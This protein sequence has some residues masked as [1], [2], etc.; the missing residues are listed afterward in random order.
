MKK[1]IQPANYAMKSQVILMG[2]SEP[3][4]SSFPI[5]L[6]GFSDSEK[7]IHFLLVF[8]AEF[9]EIV[10]IFMKFMPETLWIPSRNERE[11]R[12]PNNQVIL[13]EY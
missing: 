7:G 11:F 5:G 1:V 10:W 4:I 9:D 2:F 13:M 6:L 3:E 8:K 12:N